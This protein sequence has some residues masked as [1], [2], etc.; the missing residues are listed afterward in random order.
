MTIYAPSFFFNLFFAFPF[1]HIFCKGWGVLFVCAK[2]LSHTPFFFHFKSYMK[3]QRMP[4][5]L[6]F[7]VWFFFSIFAINLRCVWEFCVC[8]ATHTQ[9]FFFQIFIYFFFNSNYPFYSC[10]FNFNNFSFVFSNFCNYFS[11]QPFFLWFFI[12]CFL[13]KNIYLVSTASNAFM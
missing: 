7:F 1:F 2:L 3:A 10:L 4:L 8:V 9:T 6:C 5:P 11:N 13:L 12:F